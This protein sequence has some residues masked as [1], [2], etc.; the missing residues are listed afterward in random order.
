MAMERFKQIAELLLINS[1]EPF[2]S[3]EFHGGEPLLL[4]DEW[5][6][7]AVTYAQGLAR[8]YKRIRPVP[9]DDQRHAAD[10]GALAQAAQPRHRLRHEHGRPPDINDL[11]RGGGLAV[12]RAVRLVQQASHRVRRHYGA[13]PGQL[14]GAWTR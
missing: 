9:A 11:L 1:R 6:E 7:E 13:Q 2:L 12:E 5:Y 4:S 14:P 8:Q 10:R 3:L